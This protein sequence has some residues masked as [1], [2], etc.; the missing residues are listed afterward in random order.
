M[1]RKKPPALFRDRIKDFRRVP[2]SELLSNPKNWRIHSD[3]QRNA[4][5]AL[6]A[7]LGFAGAEL[8]RE[9]TDGRLMLIDG[10][11][12]K[13]EHEKQLLPVLV[14][15]LTEEEAGVL[16]ASFDPLAAMAGANQEKLDDLLTKASSD[17]LDLI[18]NRG[19]RD[20]SLDEDAIRLEYSVLVRCAN[21]QDQ[22][23]ILAEL[24]R[25]GLDTKAI[26]AGFPKTEPAEPTEPPKIDAAGKV[27]K[28]TVD[29][30]R[31]PRVKQL[32]GIFDVPPSKR[33]EHEWR[34]DFTLDKPW[35]IGLIVGPS[36]SGK[37]TLAHELFGDRIVSGWPWP[38]NQ[39]IVDGFPA[40]M[41]IHDITALLSSVGFSSPPSWTKPFHVLSNGEQFR[42]TLARTLA[43]APE[44]AVV[45][46]FTSVV[47][48][49]VAQIGSH[50]LAKTVRAGNRRFVAV[51]CHYDI[52]EWLQPDWKYDT[53]SGKFLWRSL[54]RRPEI[55]LSIRRCGPDL[56]PLFAR[57]HYLNRNL[58]RAAKCF[59]GEVNGQPACFASVIHNPHK[60]KG[61][62]REHRT[63]CL[64]DFQGVGL[65]NALSEFVASL[66]VGTGKEFRSTT[67]HPAMIRH[68]R[69]SP[70]WELIRAPELSAAPMG[71][72]VPARSAAWDRP[73]A[74]F[75]FVGSA[76]RE[77]AKVFGIIG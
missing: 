38:K 76:N 40:G 53:A 62:W 34:I 4:Y 12:R 77:A 70:L 45:D 35:Q 32:E 75:R 65:G 24:D 2:A 69:K 56:W 61:W 47:D 74:G 6:V 5:R 57:H 19:G 11:M 9:L 22:L 63:V 33:S 1:P 42:V 73:T 10:H 21:E 25:H 43:E 8:V 37:T 59:L 18:H 7:E 67:T 60:G 16:I 26:C 14:T 31:T 55:Q 66:F 23:A 20:Y 72:Y 29:I 51:S 64:P 46:E 50:A 15:D 58:H 36:G 3:A 41:S 54:R 71:G 39:S 52:E 30:E 17:A 49:T 48:R 13:E 68:R 28:R 44:L 27:I